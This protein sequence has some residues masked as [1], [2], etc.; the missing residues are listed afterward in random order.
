M[1]GLWDSTQGNRSEDP[2][3]T[4]AHSNINNHTNQPDPRQPPPGQDGSHSMIEE[5]RTATTLVELPGLT[6]RGVIYRLCTARWS[7]HR[8]IYTTPKGS[9]R[10]ICLLE[11]AKGPGAVHGDLTI[12]MDATALHCV[13][14]VTDGLRLRLIDLGLDLAVSLHL[15]QFPVS[16]LSLTKTLDS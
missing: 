5:K 4:D 3:T 14:G 7:I 16:S 9:A 1:G 15:L 10:G 6:T 2:P 8:W 13:P 12:V 11:R